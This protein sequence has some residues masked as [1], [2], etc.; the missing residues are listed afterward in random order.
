M[1]HTL[2]TQ[3]GFTLIELMV[4]LIVTTIVVAGAYTVLISTERASRANDLTVQT[5]QNVRTAMDLLAN[6]LKVAGFGATLPVGN[7]RVVVNGETLPAPLLPGDQNPAGPD[8]GP[9][10]IS[11]IVP[12]SNT[13]PPWVLD[14]DTS[15]G[16][17]QLTLKAGATAAMQTA[18]LVPGDATADVISIGGVITSHVQSVT[19]NTLTLTTSVPAPAR[20]L[21]NTPVYLL[22]CLT[23][24]V[25]QAPDPNQL[26]AGNAPCLVRGVTTA[27]APL[28]CNIPASPCEVVV[29]GIEDLQLAYGCDGCNGL[30]NSG[31]ANRVMDD[32]GVIDNVV[33]DTDFVSNSTWTVSPMLPG[34]IRLVRVG[35]LARQ[36][37]ND[38][39]FGESP[40]PASNSADTYTV[41]V[42][43]DHV[44]TVTGADR[45][46]RRRLLMR[47]IDLR[48]AGLL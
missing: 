22:R 29:D 15:T 12:V 4:G 34:T 46:F 33:T 1:V 35:I 38:L 26:C 44:I 6:D 20:F 48:N 24:Q 21:A 39:G 13:N 40:S 28:D 36:T 7:C 41:S 25:I 14:A 5:Q 32:Q 43:N 16:F 27:T 3:Q 11:I 42:A 17:S 23:Y 9:D 30:V 8:T 37:K 47:T 2:R 19:G 45:Q 31:I 10:R 18:G